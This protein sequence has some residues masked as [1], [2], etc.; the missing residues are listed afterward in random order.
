MKYEWRKAVKEIY[1]PKCP[2]TIYNDAE[3][4]TFLLEGKGIQISED[5]QLKVGS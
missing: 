4:C 1:L 2:P 5:F 3:K